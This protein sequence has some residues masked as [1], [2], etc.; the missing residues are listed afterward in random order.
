[1]TKDA[2]RSVFEK[3]LHSLYADA[4][5][6]DVRFGDPG[7]LEKRFWDSSTYTVKGHIQ[8][9]G[10]LLIFDL[11]GFG[12]MLSNIVSAQ[13]RIYPVWFAELSRDSTDITIEIPAATKVHYLPPTV[14]KD[15][16]FGYFKRD[17]KNEGTT[18]SVHYD[19]R[20]KMFEIPVEQYAKYKEFVEGIVKTMKESIVLTKG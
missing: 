11:P 15:T 2:I 18:I 17:V 6:G 3:G 14:E 19:Y 9:A 13:T 7:D 12:G 8:E 1:A 10:N 5:L 4:V 16:P 20:M